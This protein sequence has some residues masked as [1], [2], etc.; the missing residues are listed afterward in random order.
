MK[1]LSGKLLLLVSLIG[2]AASCSQ[3]HD[4][5]PV[6]GVEKSGSLES[7]RTQ[8]VATIEPSFVLS[9]TDNSSGV[10]EIPGGQTKVLLRNG[11]YE[12]VA[13]ADGTLSVH[14]YSVKWKTIPIYYAEYFTDT[15]PANAT[16]FTTYWQFTGHG[17]GR[18][19]GYKYNG[20]QNGGYIYSGAVVYNYGAN[21]KKLNLTNDGKLQFMHE[22]GQI[23]RE[24]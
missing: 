16:V 11:L 9:S 23:G 3:D 13:E 17:L 2:F 1:I 19:F 21:Y 10:F 15:V 12:L 4:V 20:T 18:M 7:A 24:F 8:T 14:V 22:N 5:T 6:A